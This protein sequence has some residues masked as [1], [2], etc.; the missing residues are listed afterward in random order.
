MARQLHEVFFS[1]RK[2]KQ[3]D[4][5]VCR[6]VACHLEE[7]SLTRYTHF[8]VQEQLHRDRGSSKTGRDS[9][10]EDLAVEHPLWCNYYKH[11]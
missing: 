6:G 7:V 8:R 9:L 1:L 2:L 3:L 4:R 10:A 11:S 5:D